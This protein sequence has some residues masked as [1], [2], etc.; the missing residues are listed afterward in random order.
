MS[1]E[2]GFVHITTLGL[3]T[4]HKKKKTLCTQATWTCLRLR[5]TTTTSVGSKTS[6]RTSR[7]ISSK[8]TLPA[9]E[10]AP[11]PEQGCRNP[12]EISVFSRFEKLV[13]RIERR[14]DVLDTHLAPKCSLA[15]SKASYD[16]TRIINQKETLRFQQ[17]YL[18]SKILFVKRGSP[19]RDKLLKSGGAGAY[20]VHAQRRTVPRLSRL[21]ESQ[22]WF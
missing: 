1:R 8:P 16:R 18:F 15:F 3:A 11:A 17:R 13:Y 14:D 9:L 12:F 21:K 6:W 19:N 20:A 22:R 4:F 7:S 2:R 5:V 10:T